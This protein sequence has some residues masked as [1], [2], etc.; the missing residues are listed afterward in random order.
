MNRKTLWGSDMSE[1]ENYCAFCSMI[2]SGKDES[3]VHN[4]LLSGLCNVCRG[5]QDEEEALLQQGYILALFS[6]RFLVQTV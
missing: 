4:V 5:R 6:P 1:L 3:F 2:G